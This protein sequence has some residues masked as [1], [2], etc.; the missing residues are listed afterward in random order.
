MSSKMVLRVL[1][2]KPAGEE[3]VFEP[4]ASCVVGRGADC[5]L[6]LPADPDCMDVSRRHCLLLVGSAGASV[7]DLGSL[8]GTFLNGLMIGRR[9]AAGDA[10]FEMADGDELRVGGTV[11]EVGYLDTPAVA[12]RTAAGSATRGATVEEYALAGEFV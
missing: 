3:Y 1:R 10:E 8:N 5:D 6:R 9:G 4:P 11:F 7:R 12:N 2:G